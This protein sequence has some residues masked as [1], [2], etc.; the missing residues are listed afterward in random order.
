M[1]KDEGRLPTG[2]F[3]ARGLA[4]AVAMAREFGLDHLAIPTNGNAKAA[5]AA[6]AARAGLRA[7]VFCPSD[8]PDINIREIQQQ[9]ATTFLVDGPINECGKIVGEGRE[10]VGWFDVSTLMEPDRIEGKKTM[11]LELT[12]QFGWRLPDVIFYPA[13]GGTG[14]IGMWK[15]CRSDR[16]PLALEARQDD[17]GCSGPDRRKA[18]VTRPDASANRGE[19]ISR[20]RNSCRVL[21]NGAGPGSSTEPGAFEATARKEASALIAQPASDASGERVENADKTSDG[22]SN[23][24]D[25]TKNCSGTRVFPTLPA[26]Q[27]ALQ[28]LEGICRAGAQSRT[29]SIIRATLSGSASGVMP[30]PRL[31]MCGPPRERLRRCAASRDTSSSPPVTRWRRIEIALNATVGPSGLL[32]WRAAQCGVDGVVERDAIGAGCRGEAHRISRRPRAERR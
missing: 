2:S 7:T 32:T 15:A 31:K 6:Y 16:R 26:G 25:R 3:K 22:A 18:Q 30:C 29:A 17:I 13:G 12:Q 1:V 4:L 5:M 10:A 27:R 19:R 24:S 28:G 20:A 14:L 8:M 11:G 9:G 23:G 21:G